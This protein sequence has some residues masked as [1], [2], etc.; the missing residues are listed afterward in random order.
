MRI[1]LARRMTDRWLEA[2]ELAREVY[3][4]AYGAEAVRDPDAFVLLDAE[5]GGTGSGPVPF[6]A[7][8]GLT[9]GA[10]GPL[11]SEGYLDRP[12]EDE[13]AA[14][15]PG[16]ADRRRVVEVGPLA[17]RRPA[18][19]RE[20]IRV[21]PVVAWILGMD[22]VLCT[23]T[24][25]VMDTFDASGIEF[26]RFRPADPARLGAQGRHWGTYY[27]HG[28]Q[29]GV[30]PLNSMPRLFHDT[31]GRYEFADMHLAVQ[32]GEVVAHAGR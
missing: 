10:D 30:I 15:L 12:V 26:V 21:A 22:Y 20:A 2:A 6:Q 18:L 14:R 19:G 4:K 7:C 8:A 5:Q 1:T 9:F 28:P 13:I 3:R 23:A 27:A 29:V 17:T 16:R 25:T 32:D 24:T 31:T 11:F